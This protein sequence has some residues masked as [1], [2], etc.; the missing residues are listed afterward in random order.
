[1]N[2]ASVVIALR[3]KSLFGSQDFWHAVCTESKC[4][5]TLPVTKGKTMFFNKTQTR[6]KTTRQ[7][8]STEQLEPKAMFSVSPV[9][10]V[11]AL[12][13]GPVNQASVEDRMVIEP[14]FN[15]GEDSLMVIEPVFNVGE[16][17]RNVNHPQYKIAASINFSTPSETLLGRELPGSEILDLPSRELLNSRL[18]NE[19][20]NTHYIDT[21]LIDTSYM[22]PPISEAIMQDIYMDMFLNSIVHNSAGGMT[23]SEMAGEVAQNAAEEVAGW[24]L[25]GWLGGLWGGATTLFQAS[26]TGAKGASA[27]CEDLSKKEERYANID[28]MRDDDVETCPELAGNEKQDPAGNEEQ[29]PKEEPKAEETKDTRS[30]DDDED[31]CFPPIILEHIYGDLGREEIHSHYMG[32]ENLESFVDVQELIPT[33]THLNQPFANNYS[34]ATNYARNQAFHHWH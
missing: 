5:T 15:V 34:N 33:Q 21:S 8:L 20:H 16:N 4:Q 32:H 6:R 22:Q 19:L 2:F 3:N 18:N 26:E 28:G 25:T 14:V 1:M 7:T 9:E 13:V 17:G 12:D 11:V 24:S 30:T 23:G 29:D 27:V 31:P 10:P